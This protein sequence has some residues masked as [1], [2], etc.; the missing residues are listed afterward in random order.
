[1]ALVLRG[2]GL[3]LLGTT[4]LA[5]AAPVSAQIRIDITQGVTQ[6]MPVAVPELFGASAFEQ[7]RGAD[8][9]DVIANNLRRSGIFQPLDRGAFLQS[10]DDLR[11]GPRFAD[12]R[13][14]NAQ[15][16]I[17][18]TVTILDDGQLRAD[19]RLWDVV[20]ETQLAGQSLTTF[21][22]NWRE[23]AH[24]ISDTVFQRLTGEPGYFNTRL[25]YVSETGPQ[26]ARIKRLAIMDQD[27]GNHEFLTDGGELVLTPRFSPT[28]ADQVIAYM[29]YVDNQP[30]VYLLNLESRQREVLGDFP[31]MTFSPR[32]S[33]DGNRVVFSWAQNGNSDIYA[34]DV[35]TRQ[36]QRL[37]FDPGID[38]SPS[39]SPDGSRIAFESDRGGSQQVYVMNADGTDPTRITFGTGRFGGPVWSPRGD[40]IAFTNIFGGR[41]HIGV[42]RPDGS[43]LRLLADSFH[44]EGPTW[45]PNG[46]ALIYFSQ[47]PSGQGS[48]ARLIGVDLTGTHTWPVP[49]PQNG[50]DPAWGP[51]IGQQ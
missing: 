22:D 6:P 35:R 29:A 7:E 44:V 34:M 8:I 19:F 33:P 21:P 1:M 30:R 4:L 9:A 16:L 20:S 25:V 32:F 47:T 11:A 17:S 2:I 27:G 48:I 37:T 38:T 46:R 50:S 49:T 14:I 18:G 41:F 28:P 13:L 42:I 10:P 39:F 36:I 15:A 3:M 12:W 23:V 40:L 26:E 5:L 24:R 31:G 43:G 45:A 51:L